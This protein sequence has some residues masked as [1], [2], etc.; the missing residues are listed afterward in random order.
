MRVSMSPKGSV[1]AIRSPLPA[2]LDDARDQALVGQVP[3]H[4]PRQTELAVICARTPGQL[5]AVANPRRVPVP[6]QLSHLQARNETLGLVARLI[7]R[8]LFELRVFRR[9][10]LNELLATLVLVDRTQFRHDLSSS[11]LIEA[12]AP[13]GGLLLL[14]GREGEV[15]EAQQFPRFLVRLRG[16]GDDD[17]HSPDLV[18]L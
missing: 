2:R 1:I 17:V 3:K 15:E 12:D 13:S 8:D 4:D 7:V 11:L 14:L 18:D 16:R 9:I 6:R 10:L 5:A